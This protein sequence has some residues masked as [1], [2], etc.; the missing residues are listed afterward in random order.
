MPYIE[1]QVHR[2]RSRPRR[3]SVIEELEA[4]LE[5][6]LTRADSP[7]AVGTGTGIFWRIDKVAVSN[8]Y[9][10]AFQDFEALLSMWQGAYVCSGPFLCCGKGAEGGRLLFGRVLL[11]PTRDG[12]NETPFHFETEYV[13]AGRFVR[14]ATPDATAVSI[15]RAKVGQMAYTRRAMRF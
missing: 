11:E 10:Q 3:L 2:G 13:I 14:V 9:E 1:Q 6:N 8:P 4:A 5:S 7:A 12:V 15:A